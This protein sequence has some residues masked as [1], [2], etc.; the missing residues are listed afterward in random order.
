M[1][2]KNLLKGF[3]K[4]KNLEFV[5][6]ESTAEYGKFVAS[7]FET[8]FGTTVGNTLRRVLLSS[9]QGYA[10]SAVK[11]DSYDADGVAHTISSEFETIPNVVEDTLEVLNN[12]KQ[13]RLRLPEDVEQE[14]F[15]FEFS[16]PGT[17]TS[18]MFGSDTQLEILGEL[19]LH[20]D[21]RVLVVKAALHVE[22]VGL[23]PFLPAQH[24]HVVELPVNGT[25][26]G[27]VHLDGGAVTASE[28]RA[29]LEVVAELS[30]ESPLPCRLRGIRIEGGQAVRML[31]SKHRQ[32]VDERCRADP[33]HGPAAA[34]R[35]VVASLGLK[36]QAHAALGIGA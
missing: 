21:V 6:S 15:H 1:A 30:L 8:G 24:Q 29:P 12:L 22:E 14:T 16:G 13:I 36:Q 23:R 7:P 31:V 2:R 26:V 20:G 25:D 19:L 9:I 34:E 35:H 32:V 17:V 10:I 27:E 33:V 11:I 3:K 18:D 28:G 5:R 4:P